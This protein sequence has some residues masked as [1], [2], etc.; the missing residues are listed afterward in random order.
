[1][2]PI[3]Q[4]PDGCYAAALASITEIPLDDFP[5]PEPGE[6]SQD[7]F[8]GYRNRVLKFLWSR[9]WFLAY[10][11]KD[12]P[13]KGYSVISGMSP[14][15]IGHCCVALDG[16]V[17]HDPYPDGGGLISIDEYEVLLP[18]IILETPT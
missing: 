13:P 9:G 8:Y 16:K 3:I 6:I 17:V 18:I 12:F 14:R 15:N 11:P 7:R 1:M 5:Q 4:K 10:I 2:T